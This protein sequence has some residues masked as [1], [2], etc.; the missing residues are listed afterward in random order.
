MEIYILRH[1][2]A[3]DPLPGMRDADRALTPEGVKK[4]QT[5]LRRAR[6]AEVK[7]SVIVTSPYRRAR[8]TA[9]VAKEVLRGEGTLVESRSLTPDSSPEAVWDTIREHRSEPQLMLV[10]HEPLL[11]SVYA[12]LLGCPGLDLDVKKAS[13]GRVDADRFGAQ[14]RGV[15]CWLITPKLAAD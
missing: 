10:G 1:G 15:L 12:Y 9:D 14:P 4:L 7:P 6:E 3:E 11:G 2:I 5:V 8:Q 13:L